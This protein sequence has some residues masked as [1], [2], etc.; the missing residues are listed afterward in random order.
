MSR[1]LT[2]VVSFFKSLASPFYPPLCLFPTPFNPAKGQI[3][4]KAT[5]ALHS[6]QRILVA[7]VQNRQALQN[8]KSETEVW[9]LPLSQNVPCLGVHIQTTE[10]KTVGSSFLCL[11]LGI[12]PRGVWKPCYSKCRF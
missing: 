9:F 6:P 4:A 11:M 1:E 8:K 5:E 7:Y 10:M 12:L 3:I 2:R